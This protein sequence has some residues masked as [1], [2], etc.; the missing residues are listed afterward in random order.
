MHFSLRAALA[1][2]LLSCASATRAAAQPAIVYAVLFYSPTCGHCQQLIQNDLPPLLET[3]G[4]QV[5]ILAIDI[6]QPGGQNLYLSAIERFAIPD[7]RRGVPALVA[8]DVVLVGGRE[9]PEQFPGIIEAALAS[10]GLDWP[11]I[12]GLQEALAQLPPPASSSPTPL[13]SGS[14]APSSPDSAPTT[15]AIL[16]APALPTAIPDLHQPAIVSILQTDPTALLL[17][18][19]ALLALIAAMPIIWLTFQRARRGLEPPGRL[20]YLF[21]LLALL[22]ALVAAYL[23]SVETGG[24]LAV[25]GPIGDC[26]AVQQSAYA[27]LLGV[28]PIAALGLLLQIGLLVLWLGVYSMGSAAGRTSAVL[29]LA[30][31]AAGVLFSIYLTYLEIFVIG[32][33]CAWCLTS[34]VIVATEC[35]L[36]AGIAG[37]RL[38]PA[39][40]LSTP[41]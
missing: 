34:A 36:A 16:P 24:S 11:D 22:G 10:G 17:A 25:C 35:W 30:L 5:Q 38:R 14:A 8:G 27:R 7:T 37:W 19:L 29:L 21:P 20:R 15:A 33:V 32:A 13:A 9:I 4:D 41:V 39:P 28:V 23:L 26:N 31:S 40:D 2:L 12:P 1:V 18:S 3:Y 6:S